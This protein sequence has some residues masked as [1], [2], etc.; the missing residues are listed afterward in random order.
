MC[1]PMVTDDEDLLI[2]DLIPIL[3]KACNTQQQGEA[4][5][6]LVVQLVVETNLAEEFGDMGWDEAGVFVSQAT[7]VMQVVLRSY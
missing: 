1:P 3:N 6:F 4:L 5:T 2:P 7:L